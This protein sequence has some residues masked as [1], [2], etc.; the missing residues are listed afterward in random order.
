MD[1]NSILANALKQQGVEYMFGVVG[2]PV[3]DVAIAAQRIGIKYIGMRNEQSAAYAAQAIGYLTR[4][5]GA[6]LA[7]SGPGLLH[8][9]GGM[10]N[11]QSNG[12]PLLVIGGSSDSTQEGLGAFQ[13]C[14]QVEASRLFCKYAAR[15][16]NLSVIPLHVEKAVRSVT[17][18]RPG[19]SKN[20]IISS[21]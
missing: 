8:T 6:C 10:A 12:W 14:P 19:E 17:Y 5:P 2:I 13:E 11:A 9:I 15:P 18:G 7:V 16:A 1:G 4:K 20:Y 3:I 21:D